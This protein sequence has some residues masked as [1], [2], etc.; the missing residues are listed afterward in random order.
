LVILY[1]YT[2]IDDARSDTNQVYFKYMSEED[3]S[4][5]WMISGERED[6]GI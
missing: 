5:Y 6:T 2:Y 4:S 1:Y 3:V